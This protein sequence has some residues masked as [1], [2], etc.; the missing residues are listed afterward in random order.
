MLIGHLRDQRG[1]VGQGAV[2]V[3]DEPAD[4][5]IALVIDE[6]QARETRV[7]LADVVD[8]L[9]LPF[10][11]AERARREVLLMLARAFLVDRDE[12]EADAALAGQRVQPL[13]AM[14]EEA[15]EHRGQGEGRARPAEAERGVDR[16]EPG[17][18]G[19]DAVQEALLAPAPE[20][21]VRFVPGF[22][23]PGPHLVAPVTGDAA[24]GELGDET[25]PGSHLL[26]VRKVVEQ[27][28][29]IAHQLEERAQ[30]SVDERVQRLVEKRPVVRDLRAGAFGDDEIEE[31]VD[32]H[33]L[34]SPVRDGAEKAQRLAHFRQ[35]QKLGGGEARAAPEL[36]Q[37]AEDAAGVD[38]DRRR[39]RPAGLRGGR[40]GRGSRGGGESRHATAGERLPPRQPRHGKRAWSRRAISNRRCS[41]STGV[42]QT[43]V[44]AWLRSSKMRL[45][46]ANWLSSARLSS[47]VSAPGESF[48][49][50]IR[51]LSS[52]TRSARRR[53]P[54]A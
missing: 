25:A 34:Q 2:G 37:R 40:L 50:L 12:V 42:S 39:F 11:D 28:R 36:R 19:V 31:V 27:V 49:A 33:E 41:R 44:K 10:D 54:R 5:G 51:S 22:E 24:R 38:R 47:V 6:W 29:G 23:P 35:E 32:A 8:R 46:Q 15:P 17:T 1:V 21:Q 45:S 9:A 52:R 13:V 26:H 4:L 14:R 43:Y 20:R 53:W 30:P 3:R 48:T 16:V 18:A 7:A